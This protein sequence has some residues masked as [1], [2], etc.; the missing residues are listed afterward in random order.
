MRKSILG[1]GGEKGFRVEKSKGKLL[2]FP[3]D[4]WEKL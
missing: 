2:S 1:T 4:G 3:V